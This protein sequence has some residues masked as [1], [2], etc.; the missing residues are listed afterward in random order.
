MIEYIIKSTISLTILYLCCLVLIKKSTNY[1]TNRILLLSFVLYSLIIPLLN[2]SFNSQ[3]IVQTQYLYH[4]FSNIVYNYIPPTKDS[5]E[6]GV[7]SNFTNISILLYSLVTFVLFARFLY[8]LCVLISQTVTSERILYNGQE[9]VLVN[10]KSS[11][12]YSF[13]QTIFINRDAFNNGNIDNDLVLHEIAHKN[14]LHSIDILLLELLKVFYWFNPFIHLFEKL[15]K[16][17]HEYLADDYVVKSGIDKKEY[18]NKLINYTIRN[19]TLNLA[20]GFD[21]LLIKNRIVMLSKYEQKKRL[22]YHQAI[23]LPV[24]AL[25]FFSMA[26]QNSDSVFNLNPTEKCVIESYTNEKMSGYII[27]GDKQE[28]FYRDEGNRGYIYFISKNVEGS[29]LSNTRDTVIRRV[30]DF[31]MKEYNGKIFVENKQVGSVKKGDYI[32]LHYNKKI[33]AYTSDRVTI[34]KAY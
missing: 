33:D 23:L 13:F 29:F 7:Y 1:K 17:N 14:Q 30:G 32:I 27:N 24:V 3:Q 11:S 6:L 12:P 10:K 8:N 34:I 5:E 25:I 22:A 19:K 16:A 9:F 20:S 28:I 4:T 2:F 18:S 15:I 31:E 26:F 21:Y